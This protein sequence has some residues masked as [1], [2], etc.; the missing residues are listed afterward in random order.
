VFERFT[1]PARQ[2]VV[3]AQDEARALNHNYIGTEHLLLGLLR[4]EDGLGARVLQSLDI[5]LGEVRA[6]VAR[7][8]GQ[9]ETVPPGQIP[10]T[11]RAKKV[12]ELSMR[13]ALALGHNYI[14]TE[15]I[16]LGL[17]RENEGVACRIL[18]DFDADADK[19]RAEVIRLLGGPAVFGTE[20]VAAAGGLTMESDVM[21][22]RPHR[23][24]RRRG[25]MPR[26]TFTYATRSGPSM[27]LGWLLFGGALG[28]GIFLGWLIWR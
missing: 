22:L 4:E 6:Q 27:L 16:L 2:V 1:E 8:V 15:H 10:F 26:R 28:I 24:A 11:P 23:P 3:L 21:P 25:A 17:M 18:L 13:E 12:L 20:A 7:I 14:G 9:G 19:I 5:T